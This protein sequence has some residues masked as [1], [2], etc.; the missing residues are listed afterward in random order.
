MLYLAST[1]DNLRVQTTWSGVMSKKRNGVMVNLECSGCKKIFTKIACDVRPEQKYFYCSRDCMVKPKEEKLIGRRANNKK[2]RENNH[3]R[4]VE[5]QRRWRNENPDRIKA[6]KRAD[7][8]KHRDKYIAKQKAYTQLNREIIC[9]KQAAYYLKNRDLINKKACEW[10]KNNPEKVIA[11]REKFR[12]ENRTSLMLARSKVSAR[13]RKVKFDLTHDWFRVRL[14]AGVCE[15]SGVQFDMV[16]KRTPNSPSVDRIKPKGDY[17]MDN[18]RII[19]WSIN[20]A[21]RDWGQDYL[22]D[23]FKKIFEREPK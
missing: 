2:Y 20:H 23:V 4:V 17:T 6:M 11:R 14:D 19:L 12:L 3:D 22:F 16:G 7:W 5:N 18:C 13:M 10:Q 21:L 15:L 1:D 9:K 8:V